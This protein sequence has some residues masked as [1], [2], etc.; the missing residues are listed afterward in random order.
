MVFCL[1]LFSVPT[2]TAAPIDTLSAKIVYQRDSG[3][4]EIS[5]GE[6][7][8][9]LL[10]N[11]GTNPRWSPDGQQI[12]F[13][14]DNAI[15]LLSKKTGKIQLLARAGKARSLCFY[16]DGK[17]IIYTD[18]KLLRR[19][20]IASGKISTLLTNGP[21]YEVDMADENTRLAVTV[22]TLFSYKV[23]VF[24]LHNGSARTVS[25]GCSA[26]LS[27][28]G[29]MVTVNSKNHRILSM[30]DWKNLTKTTQIHAPKDLQFDNQLWSNNLN[31]LSSTAGGDVK[32]IYLHH[33]P[34]DT[35]Y[36]IT[37]SGDCDRA[38]LY[39]LAVSP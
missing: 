23:Q 6:K 28:D 31:W 10:V 29:N 19:V 4:Y 17:S 32:N 39:V 38:D 25:K 16:S 12:A 18:N 37:T 13:I 1:L 34:T 9:H 21:F 22:K 33:F 26:S 3:I 11:Y 2:A 7:T 35:S 36:R 5:V 27:P 24:D 20:T 14:H 30:F 8:A 15:M